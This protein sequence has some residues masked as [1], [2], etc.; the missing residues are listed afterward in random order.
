[1]QHPKTSPKDFFLHLLN[2]VML[3]IAAVGFGRIL[4]VLIN[5][6]FPDPVS[7]YYQELDSLRWAISSLIVAFPVFYFG[8][9]NL[10][11]EYK[12]EPEKKVSR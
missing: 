6:Y 4:F 5:Y 7:Y 8:T 9:R 2:I 3:Y 1:M 11:K 10:N 12:K